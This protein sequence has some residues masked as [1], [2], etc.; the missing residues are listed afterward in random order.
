M[1]VKQHNAS[2]IL[3]NL[4]YVRSCDKT[5]PTTVYVNI[6]RIHL[7]CGLMFISIRKTLIKNAVG[8]VTNNIRYVI[9]VCFKTPYTSDTV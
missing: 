5:L 4:Y 3:Y 9:I 2:L 7:S 6:S 8:L 1:T